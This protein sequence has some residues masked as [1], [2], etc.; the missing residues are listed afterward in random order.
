MSVESTK[1]DIDHVQK[2][3]NKIKET[4]EKIKDII[5][6]IS[7]VTED[8]EISSLLQKNIFHLN[9]VPKFA[10]EKIDRIEVYKL[11]NKDWKR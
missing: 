9:G 2:E 5:K 6:E 3:I 11:V 10:I 7:N 8:I 1:K 4:K